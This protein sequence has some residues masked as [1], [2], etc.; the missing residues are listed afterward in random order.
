MD[1]WGALFDLLILLGAALLLGT[2]CERLRQNAIL[3]YLLAGMLL[4]PNTLN[5]ISNEQQV[6]ALAELGVALLLFTIGLEFSWR[7]LR[8]M[9]TVALGGGTLQVIL[10]GAAAAGVA[11]LC[12]LS[13]RAAAATG[14]IIALSSTAC[15]VRVLVARA[16]LDSIHG[17]H[18]L[19][20]LLLQDLAVVPL[21][22]LVTV[23]GLGDTTPQIATA[24]LKTAGLAVLLVAG[25]F[26]LLNY[27]VPRLFG[28]Q[29][30]QQNRELP[31]LLAVVVGLGSAWAAHGIGSSPAVG[32]FVAGLL[33]AETPFARQIRADIAALRTL[34]MT[35]FFSSIGMLGDPAWA[36]GNWLAVTTV[37]AAILIGK[38]LVIWLLLRA[39]GQTHRHA[40][41]TGM[42][43][44]QVGEFSFV[45]AAVARGS[46]LLTDDQFKLIVA[47]TIATLFFTPYLV[48]GARPAAHWVISRLER[49]GLVKVMART[50]AAV[51]PRPEGHI[52]IIG[53]GPAGQAVGETLLDRAGDVWVVDLNARAVTAARRMGF[54]GFVG[55]S[56]HPQVLDDLHFAGAAAV[57]ITIPDPVAARHIIQHIKAAQPEACILARARYHVYRWELDFAGASVVV[58]EE[59]QVGM[60]LARELRRVLRAAEPQPE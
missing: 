38:P 24:L 28:L 56:A 1:V 19:G 2:L 21:V 14:S 46:G 23:L 36:A 7:R 35:L 54:H 37:V 20:I 12:G 41:S 45:L 10:T 60:R 5:V 32:A 33:L 57:V 59:Q 17:R 3:G 29:S 9:G 52:L 31:V 8:R 55:D 49:R 13:P 50:V 43:L 58:D 30:L 25:L 26:V 16:E 47:A 6:R 42:C 44:G 11:L 18:A 39:F 22:I 51:A 48:A 34:L 53:F 4:G 40:L 27:V 15:V